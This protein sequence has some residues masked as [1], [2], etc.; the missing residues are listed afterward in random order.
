MF[1]FS[2]SVFVFNNAFLVMVA[3]WCFM[4]CWRVGAS[5]VLVCSCF[6]FCFVSRRRWVF[7]VLVVRA[8]SSCA[9]GR[10]GQLS[11][12]D[13][14]R[15]CPRN[16]SMVLG[17]SPVR[18]VVANLFLHLWCDCCVWMYSGGE[19]GLRCPCSSLFVLSQCPFRQ[20]FCR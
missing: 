16:I 17:C 13:G 4:C 2:R 20:I 10:A 9:Q 19:I 15:N 14:Q 18:C 7:C 11:Q 8:R 12:R 3:C 1:V 5:G 6:I